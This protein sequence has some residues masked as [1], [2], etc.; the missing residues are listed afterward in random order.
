MVGSRFTEMAAG[1]ERSRGGGAGCPRT[2]KSWWLLAVLLLSV[3]SLP[4]ASGLVEGLYC[5]TE[6]CYDVLGVSREAVK[7]DIARAYRQL[8]RRYHPD[9][10]RLGEPGYEGETR[11]SAHTKFLLIATAYETLKV[12]QSQRGC[13]FRGHS[14][15]QQRA[16][17]LV[18]LFVSLGV[19]YVE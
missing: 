3:S 7:L 1:M 5:G 2:G 15:V 19:F 10:F 17:R 16:L 18:C 6:V 4:V 9:R 11:E 8:A 14:H 13:P 12:G